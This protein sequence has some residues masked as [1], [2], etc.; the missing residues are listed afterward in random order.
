MYF[1][2]SN[3]GPEWFNSYG[4]LDN[5]FCFGQHLC[6]SPGYA[7]GDLYFR[8]KERISALKEL[9]GIDPET[10]KPELIVINS[11]AD[12]PAWWDEQ[13][14]MHDGL[15]EQYEKYSELLD[16]FKTISSNSEVT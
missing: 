13:E 14:K 2:C 7:P 1:F 12:I 15:K 6:S 5:G 3:D 4:V 16:K 8:R 10:I 9:F 11:K